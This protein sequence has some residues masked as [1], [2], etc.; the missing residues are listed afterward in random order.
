MQR[1]Y[2]PHPLALHASAEA[3]FVEGL[4]MEFCGAVVFLLFLFVIYLTCAVR[5]GGFLMA[6]AS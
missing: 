3:A 5:P 1:P 4:D 2:R 6:R